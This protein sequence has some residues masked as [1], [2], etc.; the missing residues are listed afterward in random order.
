MLSYASASAK[1]GAKN[2]F[3]RS[4]CSRFASIATSAS[5]SDGGDETSTTASTSAAASSSNSKDDED[6]WI[7]QELRRRK[8]ARNPKNKSGGGGPNVIAP[9]VSRAKGE[10]APRPA[11]GAEAAALQFLGAFFFVLLLE[12]LALA[13]SGFFPENVD[14][15]I[16]ERIYPSYSPH[17]GVFVLCSS[18]YGLWKSKQG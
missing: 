7:E 2:G 13:A 4:K 18:L 3:L 5:P 1:G 15:F 11:D 14:A 10:A 16:T 12:G 8:R 9:A 17:V 6:L